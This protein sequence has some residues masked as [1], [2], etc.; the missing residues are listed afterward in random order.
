MLS[1]RILTI[2]WCFCLMHKLITWTVWHNLND[3]RRVLQKRNCPFQNQIKQIYRFQFFE[4]R[5]MLFF[6]EE[7]QTR[8][9][10]YMSSRWVSPKTEKFTERKKENELL[11]NY[12]K[13]RNPSIKERI[14]SIFGLLVYDL[15]RITDCFFNLNLLETFVKITCEGGDWPTL[16]LHESK[17]WNRDSI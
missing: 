9:T 2:D 7:F 11:L 16:Y 1:A 17:I 3:N 4:K 15:L 10:L 12:W 8:G 13:F 6:T 14:Q 5:N